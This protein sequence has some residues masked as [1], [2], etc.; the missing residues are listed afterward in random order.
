ML[1]VPVVV[2]AVPYLQSPG[3]LVC[4]QPLC[5]HNAPSGSIAAPCR[6]PLLQHC[7]YNP[8]FYDTTQLECT[9]DSTMWLSDTPWMPNT[10]FAGSA[11]PRIA[12]Y[13]R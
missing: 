12:T 7:E 8:V 3:L 10:K 6:C 2:S 13:A 5:A 11:F 9:A 4:T 1:M